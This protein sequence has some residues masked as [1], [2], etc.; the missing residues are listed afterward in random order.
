M[1][2]L[3]ELHDLMEPTRFE[4]GSVD[5]VHVRSMEMT[6]STL[7]L[8]C[9]SRMSSSV[10]LKKYICVCVCVTCLLQTRD[11]RAL[12]EE[13]ARILCRGGLYI[14]GEWCFRP[15]RGNNMPL[16]GNSATNNF[17]NEVTRRVYEPRGLRPVAEQIRSIL[18]RSGHFYG[19]RELSL[20]FE[21]RTIGSEIFE[22]YAETMRVLLVEGGMNAHEVDHMLGAHLSELQAIPGLK[23]KYH[24]VHARRA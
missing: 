11:Y 16:A 3:F 19:V 5:L 7:A 8:F 6:V 1:N 23:I 15:V 4:N 24:L 2:V 14:A 9:S 10:R 20:E 12:M 22:N 13:A 21:V 17:F 18:E